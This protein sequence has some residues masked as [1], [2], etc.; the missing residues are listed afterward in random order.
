M[1]VEARIEETLAEEIT[2]K[3]NVILDRS[4]DVT[5]S[6]VALVKVYGEKLFEKMGELNKSWKVLIAESDAGEERERLV[7]EIGQKKISHENTHSRALSFVEGY[8]ASQVKDTD[9]SDDERITDRSKSGAGLLVRPE[10]MKLPSFEG[11]IR[12]YARFK[13]DSKEIAAPFYSDETHQLYVMKESCLRGPAKALVE[14]MESLSDLW[15]R[16][17]DKYGDKIDLVDVVVK[18]LDGLPSMKGNDDH[19]LIQMVDTL[20]KG[21]LDLE[22][23]GARNDIANAYNVKLVE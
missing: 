11:N 7:T 3:L 12:N 17:D 9:I 20:E 1:Q 6:D 8:Y 18:D 22:A 13:R 14:N 16:L 15:A 10:K 21:I 5:A 4:D 19:K 2:A 23:I